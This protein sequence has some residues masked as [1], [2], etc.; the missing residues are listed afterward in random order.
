MPVDQKAASDYTAFIRANVALN[1]LASLPNGS[2]IPRGGTTVSIMNITRLAALV[3]DSP[4]AIPPVS[5][6]SGLPGATL[7]NAGGLDMFIV[8]YTTSGRLMW[9]ARIA[10]AG[11]DIPAS[12]D[13]DIDGNVYVAGSYTQAVTVYG[14]DG[15]AFG[16]PL[17][18]EIEGT[19][20]FLVKYTKDGD[21]VWKT[22][23]DSQTSVVATS[24]SVY[25]TGE[26]RII[27]VSGSYQNNA[28]FYGTNGG[29]A[30]I[31]AWSVSVPSGFFATYTEDGNSP[32]IAHIDG[33]SDDSPILG[34]SIDGENN[35]IVGGKY[36]GSLHIYG[37]GGGEITPSLPYDVNGIASYLIKWQPGGSI[38]WKTYIEY[39]AVTSI[40]T[41]D[42]LNVY[43]SGVSEEASVVIH[44][45]DEM[46]TPPVTI[47][48]SD[49]APFQFLVKFDPAGQCIWAVRIENVVIN[50]APMNNNIYNGITV[51]P[52]GNTYIVGGYLGPSV[53]I[54][55]TTGG[56]PV[57]SLTTSVDS[58]ASYVAKYTTVGELLWA[59]DIV[60]LPGNDDVGVSISTDPTGNVFVTGTNSTGILFN[61]ADGTA[62]VNLP[63]NN[64]GSGYA[65][66]IVKYS[67]SGIVQWAARG[68]G[69]D[70]FSF[71]NSIHADANGVYGVGGYGGYSSESPPIVFYPAGK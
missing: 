20:S 26:G 14:A 33:E 55:D 4:F 10:G 15:V 71:G 17:P 6:P 46:E 42:D 28:N 32:N 18:I 60:P 47:S 43:F 58:L 54:Y 64:G 13:T 37:I 66:F 56:D 31:E 34:I 48:R 5:E 2:Y 41:D 1:Q 11:Y 24:L 52:T 57:K 70:A 25:S 59:A 40:S 69:G 21:V 39:G 8:K 50:Y 7:E 30:G 65:S 3:R 53:Y 38:T 67:S 27:S 22:Y 49:S 62:G 29:S 61:N 63:G 51:D 12:V 44:S 36:I 23:M 19:W 35:T 9:A 16:E 68:D 45:V